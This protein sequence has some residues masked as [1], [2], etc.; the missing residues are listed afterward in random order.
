[1]SNLT[2]NLHQILHKTRDEWAKFATR[3]MG[4]PSHTIAQF[5]GYNSSCEL[6][7]TLKQNESDANSDICSEFC[8]RSLTS[9]VSKT[10]IFD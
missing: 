8:A 5:Y 2:I 10:T 3:E 4:I 6:E 7:Q 9:N 1:M